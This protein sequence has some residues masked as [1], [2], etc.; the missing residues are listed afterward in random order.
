MNIMQSEKNDFHPIEQIGK[1]SPATATKL[2]LAAAALNIASMTLHGIHATETTGV[3]NPSVEASKQATPVQPKDL[4][5]DTHVI[6]IE[7]SHGEREPLRYEDSYIRQ[8]IRS[9]KSVFEEVSNGA[10]TLP[11]QADIHHIKLTPDGLYTNKNSQQSIEC[12]TDEQLDRVQTQ[13]LQNNELPAATSL[14]TVINQGESCSLL[15][16]SGAAMVDN[17]NGMRIGTMYVGVL[18]DNVIL[19]EVGHLLGLSHAATLHCDNPSPNS[20]LEDSKTD[21]GELVGYGCTIPKRPDSDQ[22]DM[23]SDHSTVMGGILADSS[24][25]L[26]ERFNANETT[27]LVPDVAKNRDILPEPQ[28]YELSTNYGKLRT[29]T[30]ALPPEHPLRKIDARI[31]KVSIG[32]MATKFGDTGHAT[33][34][35]IAHHE[36]QSYRLT[37]AFPFIAGYDESLGPVEVYHD[38]MLGIR[39]VINKGKNERSVTVDVE[40]TK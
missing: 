16:I 9:A 11:E 23:Y 27:K 28:T 40:S 22:L 20:L 21:I 8:T 17:V 14:M 30:L 36:E 38:E 3:T 6:T 35:V 24:D 18:T 31:N 15:P 5:K 37:S 34:Q 2:A 19:H 39:V 7:H 12:Y 1:L 4:M 29:V 13:Y 33:V 25:L 10:L 26:T 32:L